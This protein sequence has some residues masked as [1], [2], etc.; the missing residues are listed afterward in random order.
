V[1]AVVP[2][3]SGESF[4]F[5]QRRALSSVGC[6]TRMSQGST[7]TAQQV[8]MLPTTVLPICAEPATVTMRQGSSGD[9]AR[10]ISARCGNWLA[11]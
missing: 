2:R 3:S 4:S 1:S 8:K 5:D 9:S 11:L 6:V 10:K 7:S